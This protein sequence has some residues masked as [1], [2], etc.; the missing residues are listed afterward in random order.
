[1]NTRTQPT[2]SQPPSQ[3]Y[4]DCVQGNI[5]NGYPYNRYHQSAQSDYYSNGMHYNQAQYTHARALLEVIS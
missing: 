1:M 5:H 3:T 4:Q 2:I